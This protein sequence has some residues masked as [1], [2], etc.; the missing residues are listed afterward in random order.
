MGF[1]T[2]DGQ[3]KFCWQWLT[4]IV[5]KPR[6]HMAVLSAI[7][8]PNQ[9]SSTSIYDITFSNCELLVW[10]LYN[11]IEHPQL[12]L[13][14]SQVHQSQSHQ[15]LSE[16]NTN[17]D[18]EQYCPDPFISHFKCHIRTKSHQFWPWL[19]LNL[20]EKAWLAREPSFLIITS[21]PICTFMSQM[22]G[23]KICWSFISWTSP[24]L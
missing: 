22:K 10:K 19:G 21:L 24:W 16:K 11:R 15:F 6:P 17:W 1:S 14:P 23:P 18:H 9:N 20:L 13:T 7:M 2:P 12:L 5:D 4:N 8:T 3:W